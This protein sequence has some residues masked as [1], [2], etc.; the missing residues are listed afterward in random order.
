MKLRSFRR[1]RATPGV[2]ER[3]T[4]SPGDRVFCMRLNISPGLVLTTLGALLFAGCE[5]PKRPAAVPPPPPITAPNNRT[6]PSRTAGTATP[7][8]ATP[9]PPVTPTR[10]R[11]KARQAA[12]EKASAEAGKPAQ[13]TGATAN[14]PS[15]STPAASAP[16]RPASDS[17]LSSDQEIS[18]GSDTELHHD[19]QTTSQLLDSTLSRLN[20]LRKPLSAEEQ[21]QVAQIRNYVSQSRAAASQGDMQRARNLALKGHLLA[22]DLAHRH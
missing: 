22:D 5:T 9:A 14:L 6:K 10:R 8:A 17:S 3:V 7:P 19:R 16:A 20:S 2:C 21:Q 12:A 11:R 13:K 18:V 1:R 4:I 15:P